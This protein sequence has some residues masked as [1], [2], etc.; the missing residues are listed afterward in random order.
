MLA[1]RLLLALAVAAL[2]AEAQSPPR[3]YTAASRSPKG[4]YGDTDDRL[5]E[6]ASS[7]ISS[8]LRAAG[9]S[10]VALVPKDA[11]VYNS[12]ANTWSAAQS[13]QTLQETYNLCST[14]DTTG[15]LTAFK[16]QLT[17]SSCSGTVV[18]W[19]AE[20]K[21]G[22]VATVRHQLLLANSI[23]DRIRKTKV[24]SFRSAFDLLSLFCM[25]AGRALLRR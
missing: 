25:L 16:D 3:D 23:A 1:S 4:V 9:A 10:T 11:I 5:D 22:T 8:A 19:D 18:A 2:T 20:T 14:D 13:V 21:T 24:P 6:S 7:G 15:A 12:D 17:L